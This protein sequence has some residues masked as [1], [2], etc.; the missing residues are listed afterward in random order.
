LLYGHRGAPA[1]RPENTLVSFERAIELGATAL[2]TDVHMTRDGRIVVSHDDTGQRAAGDGALIRE[3]TWAE[4]SAWDAG[5][6][7]V[8]ADGSRPY[9]DR[10]IG[11]PSLDE[12]LEAFPDVRINIDI[13][14]EAPSMVEPL[15][16]VLV[17]HDADDRITLASFSS[18]TMKQ[19]RALGFTGRTVLSRNEVVALVLLP[20][21]LGEHLIEGDTAQVPLRAGPFDLASRGFIDKCHRVGLLVEYWT[22]NTV[23]EAERLLT[24]GADGIMT[25][26]PA[27]LA[28]VFAAHVDGD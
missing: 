10:G 5:R 8:A 11:M 1:E 13:K 26:D 3:S 20:A 9:A 21:A 16:A 27:A 6:Q 24:L 25:D 7:Y 15:L 17:E 23:A 2:E 19:V 22:I 14:Q 4:V 12:L 28:P 18:A